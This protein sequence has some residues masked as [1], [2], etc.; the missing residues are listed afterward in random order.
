MS[1]AAVKGLVVDACVGTDMWKQSTMDG[2]RCKV[3]GAE[4][5]LCSDNNSA[6]I[7]GAPTARL[8]KKCEKCE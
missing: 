5:G 6:V 3:D 8:V 2:R 4:G 7:P 1:L